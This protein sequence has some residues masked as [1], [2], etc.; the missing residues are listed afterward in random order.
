[1]AGESNHTVELRLRAAVE[2]SPS[3]LLMVDT[4]G[5]IVLVNREIERLFG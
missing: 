2:S 3:G 4:E 1:M 5:R